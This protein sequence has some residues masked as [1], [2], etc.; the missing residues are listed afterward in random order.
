MKQGTHHSRSHQYSI[1]T[2]EAECCSNTDLGLG[3]RDWHR[4]W[5]CYLL[6]EWPYTWWY[7]VSELHRPL[8]WEKGIID[9]L[10]IFLCIGFPPKWDDCSEAFFSYLFCVGDL[11]ISLYAQLT[12]SDCCRISL[13]WTQPKWLNQPRLDELLSGF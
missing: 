13:K 2:K 3:N 10:Y 4:T 7:S 11:C 12:S 8:M 1:L 9:P 5:I 6:A